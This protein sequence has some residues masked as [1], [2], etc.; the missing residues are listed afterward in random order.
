MTLPPDL[1]LAVHEKEKLR[2]RDPDKD[3]EDPG[4]GEYTRTW[5]HIVIIPATRG[6]TGRQWEHEV[7][8]IIIIM[9][10][11]CLHIGVGIH[12]IE[13]CFKKTSTIFVAMRGCICCNISWSLSQLE[14]GIY[15]INNLMGQ[16]SSSRIIIV[17]IIL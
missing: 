3:D 12:Y 11:N 4:F 9:I 14:A 17:S 6:S 2:G 1:D 13:I 15:E 8:I 10:Q 16:I 7:Q 5:V